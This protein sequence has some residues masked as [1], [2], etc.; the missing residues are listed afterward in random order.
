ML[1]F[2]V[3][4]SILPLD[5]EVTYDL[6]V[7]FAVFVYGICQVVGEAPFVVATRTVGALETVLLFCLVADL[8]RHLTPGTCPLEKGHLLIRRR[9]PLRQLAQ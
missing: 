6:R 8:E 4:V 3:K 1:Y 2:N 5:T 9:L 7:K